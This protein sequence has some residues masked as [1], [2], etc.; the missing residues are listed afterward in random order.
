[1]ILGFGSYGTVVAN[2]DG[3]VTKRVIQ[4]DIYREW[5][6]MQALKGHPN[7]VRLIETMKYTDGYYG[8][9]M[10]KYECNLAQI[11]PYVECNIQ[12]LYVALQLCEGLE[13]CH[14]KGIAHRDLKPENILIENNRV[15]LADFGCSKQMVGRLHTKQVTT[16]PYICPEMVFNIHDRR[17]FFKGGLA[18]YDKRCDIWSLGC[19][20]F[21]LHTKKCRFGPLYSKTPFEEHYKKYF[22]T[23]KDEYVRTPESFLVSLSKQMIRLIPRNRMSITRAKAAIENELR[24]M[25]RVSKKIKRSNID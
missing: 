7:I 13:Y 21:E 22:L 14:S 10:E 3:T 12:L 25:A 8:F 9:I 24:K 18:I 20:L 16:Q 23:F 5:E 1:M 19:I 4:G 17:E 15:V 2:D 6:C 11:N